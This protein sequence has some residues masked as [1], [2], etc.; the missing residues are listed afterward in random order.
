MASLTFYQ[1]VCASA[2]LSTR[3][4][5]SRPRVPRGDVCA[6]VPLPGDVVPPLESRALRPESLRDVHFDPPPRTS[7]ST[8]WY[9]GGGR[10]AALRLRRERRP[11]WT[12]C[13][14]RSRPPS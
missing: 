7:D 14:R 11:P 8:S 4:F 3:V 9:G 10:G 1:L 5:P 6:A 12:S 2:V 13:P